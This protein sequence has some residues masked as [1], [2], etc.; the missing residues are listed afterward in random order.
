M[1]LQEVKSSQL[2]L[3]L[4]IGMDDEGNPIFRYK[5]FNNVKPEATADSLYAIASSFAAL[6]THGLYEVVRNDSSTLSE[7]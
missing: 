1:A 2:R 3:V 5:N 7:E 4:N 6:Q